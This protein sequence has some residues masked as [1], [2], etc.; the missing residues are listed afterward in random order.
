MLSLTDVPR[1]LGNA[2]EL[3][4]HPWEEAAVEDDLAVAQ[5]AAPARHGDAAVQSAVE[6]LGLDEA[7][8]RK[9]MRNFQCATD[10]RLK[11]FRDDAGETLI[12]LATDPGE[13][14]PLPIADLPDSLPSE[15][16]ERLRRAL[17]AAEETIA[18]PRPEDDADLNQMTPMTED[19]ALAAQ[20]E[21]LGYL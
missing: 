17:D 6:E 15:T 12:D 19:T 1:M 7:G 5:H 20:M 16:V 21:L 11:L 2:L 9:L 4:G 10:G 14:H 13:I 18:P 8:V 3:A